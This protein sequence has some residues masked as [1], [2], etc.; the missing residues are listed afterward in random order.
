[1][2]M[3]Q[4]FALRSA[5][6]YSFQPAASALCGFAQ[7][8]GPFGPHQHRRSEHV[9]NGKWYPTDTPFPL[10]HIYIYLDNI[11]IYINI[12]YIYI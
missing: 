1:M 12:L 7:A 8:Q 3:W 11:N 4:R 5:P 9:F 10:K 6:I 2:M